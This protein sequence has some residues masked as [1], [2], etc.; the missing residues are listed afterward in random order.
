MTIILRTRPDKLKE[1]LESRGWPEKKVQENVEAEMTD[2]C[3]TEAMDVNKRV[4]EVDT[5]DKDE[6]D[7][8]LAIRAIMR[9]R[10]GFEPGKTDWLGLA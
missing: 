1:R 8:I 10:R 7:V 6:T 2:V 3:L 9:G 5:T 4:F